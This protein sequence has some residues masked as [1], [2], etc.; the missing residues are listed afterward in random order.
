[1][2]GPAPDK[3]SSLEEMPA[4][5]GSKLIALII[6]LWLPLPVIALGVLAWFGVS[7]P[8]LAVVAVGTVLSLGLAIAAARV[9]GKG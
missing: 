7:L 1:M 5:S 8:L 6:A 2:S 3:R 4:V 9:S